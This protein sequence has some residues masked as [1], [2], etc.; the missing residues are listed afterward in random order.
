V[1]RLAERDDASGPDRLSKESEIAVIGGGIFRA[2]GNGIPPQP[3]DRGFRRR[4]AQGRDD[5]SGRFNPIFV[6]GQK[7][8]MKGDNRNRPTGRPA[9]AGQAFSFA[10]EVIL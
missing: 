3:F 10:A 8:R 5:G 7:K 2:E 1:C 9:M 4:F 6:T